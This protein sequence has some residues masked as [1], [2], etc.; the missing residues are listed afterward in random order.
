MT[1]CPVAAGSVFSGKAQLYPLWSEILRDLTPLGRED[2][3]VY[4]QDLYPLVN[5]LGGAEAVAEVVQ[6]IRDVA[7]WW[8]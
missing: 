7:R 6:A 3:L 8:D 1:P 2:A 4:V 5:T